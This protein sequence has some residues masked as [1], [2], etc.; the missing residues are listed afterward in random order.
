MWPIAARL[1]ALEQ[2]FL[3]LI[4]H[5]LV[6]KIVRVVRADLSRGLVQ[7]R[8][9]AIERGRSCQ[10]CH[11]ARRPRRRFQFRVDKEWRPTAPLKRPSADCEREPQEFA[12]ERLRAVRIPRHAPNFARVD[13]RQILLMLRQSHRPR[14]NYQNSVFVRAIVVE[15]FGRQDA[16]ECSAAYDYHVERPGIGSLRSIH[17]PERF[18]EAVAHVPTDDVQSEVCS[19]RC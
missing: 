4:V 2:P 14:F 3:Q 13:Q 12:I 8:L 5:H 19:R 1:H 17:A 15:Q 7:K 9:I 6:D 16:R 11:D 18:I 10:I